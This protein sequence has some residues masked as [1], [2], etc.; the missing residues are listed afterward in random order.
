MEAQGWWALVSGAPTPRGAVRGE[1][2][3]LRLAFV[4]VQPYRIPRRQASGV[5]D[6]DRA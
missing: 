1:H 4:K 2:T 5:C 3:E 6:V